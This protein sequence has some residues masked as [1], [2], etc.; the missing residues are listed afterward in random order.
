ME[1]MK[2]FQKG[3]EMW[4]MFVE[5]WDLVQKYWN[6][7]DVDEYWDCMIAACA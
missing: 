6:V 3:S 7:E 4:S 5:Y 1:W 2:K